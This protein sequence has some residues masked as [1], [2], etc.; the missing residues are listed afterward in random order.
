MKGEILPSEGA[1]VEALL[2]PLHVDETGYM[3][4]PDFERE[5]TRRAQLGLRMGALG[6]V[7]AGRALAAYRERAGR[8]Q[9]GAWLEQTLPISQQTA[10]R[11]MRIGCDQ[12]IARYTRSVNN[13]NAILPNDALILDEIAGYEPEQFDGLIDQ[14][15]IHAEMRRG[16]LKRHL[17][18]ARHEADE[19]PALLDLPGGKY[20]AILADPPW[21]FQTR[22][23]G[24]KGRSAENHYPTMT[25]REIASLGVRDLAAGDAVLFLWITSDML[26]EAAGIM[27][28][29][30]FELKSTAF[31]W[32]KDGPAGRGYW[33]RKGTEICLLGTRGSPKRLNADVAEVLHAPRAR[34]SQK[35]EEAYE[36]IERLVA[37]PYLELFARQPRDG[38]DAWGND[39]ALR[40]RPHEDNA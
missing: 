9:W 20:R 12:N 34:H 1:I 8:G 6:F 31:V 39:P 2:A 19:T 35:P 24:G 27:A 40:R 25:L 32:V 11:I 26:V 28:E 7:V 36:R 37:G 10:A 18:A 13:V 23:K 4:W 30:T 14:G 29:W 22:G 15:V 3:D 21:P 17:V 33:T 38:W 16:D 5:C